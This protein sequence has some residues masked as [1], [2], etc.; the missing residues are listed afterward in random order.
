MIADPNGD[1]SAALNLLLID[2]IKTERPSRC[3]GVG[4]ETLDVADYLR[5]VGDSNDCDSEDADQDWKTSIEKVKPE[6][7]LY[8]FSMHDSKAIEYT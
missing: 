6:D 8:M 2:P 7:Y 3:D 5:T 4:L 1:L